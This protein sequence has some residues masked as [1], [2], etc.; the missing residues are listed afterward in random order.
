MSRRFET[1]VRED[2]QCLIR[3]CPQQ[4]MPKAPIPICFNHLREI[5]SLYDAMRE[6]VFE[7]PESDLFAMR[8]RKKQEAAEALA[9]R[10]ENSV[11]YYVRLGDHVKIGT[12]VNLAQRIR[13]FY[14]EQDSVLATE[15]GSYDVE[16]YRHRQFAAE[17]IDKGR[18][19]FN[20]SPRL[21][22]HIDRMRSQMTDDPPTETAC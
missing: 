19:L 18:E 22:R 20:P 9:R 6:L 8:E 17:R 16:S 11:V 14:V 12:T 4:P 10:G 5:G 7:T 1:D 2:E 3:R 15:P 13:S 21:L